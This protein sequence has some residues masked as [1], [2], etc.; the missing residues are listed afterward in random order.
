MKTLFL[1]IDGVLHPLSA[2]ERVDPCA[3]AS[4]AIGNPALFFYAKLLA[5]V[6][7]PHDVGIV[8]HST[9]RLFT[10][11]DDLRTMLGPLARYFAGTT[12][13]ATRYEGICWRVQQDKITDY[14][15]LDDS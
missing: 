6:L 2:G 14:R 9:W 13:R 12:P 7:A 10:H 3:L 4:D 1:D 11:E 8:V 5:D 15:I